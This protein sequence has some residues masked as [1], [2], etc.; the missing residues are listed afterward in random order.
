MN[1]AEIGTEEPSKHPEVLALFARLSGLNPKAMAEAL[2]HLEIL[3]TFP[4]TYDKFLGVKDDQSKTYFSRGIKK[5]M[6][7]IYMGLARHLQARS[8]GSHDL[9]NAI[10]DFLDATLSSLMEVPNL[11]S[12]N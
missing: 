3:K 10:F 11:I 6:E 7:K 4:Q 8:Q 9:M 1:L 12:M 5:E 2:C